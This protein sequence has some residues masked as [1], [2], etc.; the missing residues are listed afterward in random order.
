MR[1]DNDLTEALSYILKGHWI[2]KKQQPDIYYYVKKHAWE[3]KRFL[4]T[5]YGWNILVRSDFI[6]V[7]RRPMVP[8]SWMGVD[9]FK[10]P[11]D[12]TLL[13][14]AMA[15]IEEKSV[16]TPF[17]LSEMTEDIL[18]QAPEEISL[19][20]V[21]Y[22]HRCSLVRVLVYL[23]ENGIIER[24]EGDEHDFESSNTGAQS[25]LYITGITSRYLLGRSPESLTSYSSFNE[26]WQ[27]I[28]SFEHTERTQDIFRHL[29]LEPVV[30]R[31][32][33][34]EPLFV[35]MRQY[36]HIISNGAERMGFSFVL[37]K[38][39]AAFV[40]SQREAHNFPSRKAVDEIIIQVATL[41]CEE[42]YPIDTY[43]QI[44]LEWTQWINILQHTKNRYG[45]LWTKSLKE[46]TLD[47]L[48]T[49]L[50]QRATE[51]QYI[52][53][54][55]ENRIRL[56]PI[57]PRMIANRDEDIHSV[58]ETKKLKKDS[59]TDLSK[60]RRISV[61]V[62]DE[63]RVPKKIEEDAVTGRR[64]HGEPSMDSLF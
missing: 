35:R 48:S 47:E 2:S 46:M 51:W 31:T 36:R 18:R 20:W 12:Y 6:Q 38:D 37:T 60:T 43:G 27:D 52:Q 34:T 16:D 22:Q 45:D 13:C 42:D 41:V 61:V 9:N 49:A 32:P 40:T 4:Q 14:L 63:K 17:L 57:V 3:L 23:V 8:S 21:A 29:L 55:E 24:I 1:A 15:F 5:Y 44:D 11:L 64:K 39:Y 30:Y 10:S 59:I 56:L 33:K 26:F 54:L 62:T 7:F 28:E 53:R 58:K 25:L 19:D 50:L